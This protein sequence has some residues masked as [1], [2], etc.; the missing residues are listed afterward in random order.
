[1]LKKLR[2]EKG[3]TQVE[4]A[5]LLGVSRRAW[6]YWEKSP[7]SICGYKLLG[8]IDAINKLRK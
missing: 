1:M 3:Y 4:I 5:E 8:I 7:K 2:K 6:Q